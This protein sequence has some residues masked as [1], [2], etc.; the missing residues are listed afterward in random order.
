MDFIFVAEACVRGDQLNWSSYLLHELFEAANDVYVLST[1]FVFGFLLI[2]LAMSKWCA[3][4]AV[5]FEYSVYCC[6]STNSGT[7]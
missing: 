1:Y 2:P 5:Y 6:R 4:R 3:Q 7:C